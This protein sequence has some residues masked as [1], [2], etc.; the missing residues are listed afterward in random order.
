MLLGKRVEYNA[1]IQD[2][3]RDAF[4][5]IMDIAK[6]RGATE[7]TIT[8]GKRIVFPEDEVMECRQAS[9]SHMAKLT[10]LLESNN[11]RRVF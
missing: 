4:R 7:F 2:P 5:L 1:T 9:E 8:N 6:E 10:Q 11:L 3:T